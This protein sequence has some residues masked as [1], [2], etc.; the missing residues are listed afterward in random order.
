VIVKIG[1][2][3]NASKGSIMKRYKL[4]SNEPRQL[5]SAEIRRLN[6]PIDYSDIPPLSDE[7]FTKAKGASPQRQK[8]NS[9]PRRKLRSA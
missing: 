7:F 8:G 2:V 5:T 9:R 1:G 3:T 4:S 6:A